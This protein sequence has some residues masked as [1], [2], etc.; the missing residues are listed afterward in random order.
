MAFKKA[1]FYWRR[2]IKA[3]I[4]VLMILYQLYTRQFPS[5]IGPIVRKMHFFVL[6]VEIIA[7]TAQPGGTFQD[8]RL[9]HAQTSLAGTKIHSATVT[10]CYR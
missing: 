8:G 9:T 4:N 5:L 1:F 10:E 6:L 3:H 2:V 7:R